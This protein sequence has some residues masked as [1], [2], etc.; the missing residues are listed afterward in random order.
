MEVIIMRGLINAVRWDAI[1]M[2][3]TKTYFLQMF[4]SKGCKALPF[5]PLKNETERNQNY[6]QKYL[7]G[8]CFLEFSIA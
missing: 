5:F 7:K 1:L 4:H 3:N 8:A 2:V 6:H